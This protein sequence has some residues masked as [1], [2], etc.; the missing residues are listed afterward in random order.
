MCSLAPTEHVVAHELEQPGAGVQGARRSGEPVHTDPVASTRFGQPLQF[1][2]LLAEPIADHG[3]SVGGGTVAGPDDGA[4]GLAQLIAGADGALDVA[5][6]DVSED[7]A[8][9]NEV[10]GVMSR[11]WSMRE[12]SPVTT[13]TWSSFARR[14]VSEAAAVLQASNSTSRARTS[15]RR[16]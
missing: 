11:Y 12:A 6:G 4:T 7:T 10:R 3:H 1:E 14:A 15:W 2:T 16:G 9:Q 8:D 13:S 5:V